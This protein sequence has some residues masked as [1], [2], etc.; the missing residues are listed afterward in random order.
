V[1]ILKSKSEIE[2]DPSLE[3]LKFSEKILSGGVRK[4]FK[5]RARK[6]ELLEF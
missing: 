2:D 6:K 4:K 3:K 5:K 1:V